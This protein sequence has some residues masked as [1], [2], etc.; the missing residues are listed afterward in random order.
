MLRLSM[1]TYS[2]ENYIVDAASACSCH[3]DTLLLLCHTL[4][5]HDCMECAELS[6]VS[7]ATK[8]SPNGSTIE[9]LLQSS[10]YPRAVF[11]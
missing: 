8:Y 2:L 4:L 9:I 1:Q 3:L 10:M 6:I 5:Q 11:P 7:A